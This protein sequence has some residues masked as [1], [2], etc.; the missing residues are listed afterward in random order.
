M[1]KLSENEGE[2]GEGSNTNPRYHLQMAGPKLHRNKPFFHNKKLNIPEDYGEYGLGYE[3]VYEGGKAKEEEDNVALEEKEE[4]K[5]EDE[6]KAYSDDK[7][8]AKEDDGMNGNGKIGDKEEEE[9]GDDDYDNDNAALE[10]EEY[11]YEEGQGDLHAK[12]NGKNNAAIEK[13]Q[14]YEEEGADTKKDEDLDNVAV[15]EVDDAG[16][17]H[18]D[19]GGPVFEDVG[20][21]AIKQSDGRSGGKKSQGKTKRVDGVK[22]D[23]EAKRDKAVEKEGG[24]LKE[25]VKALETGIDKME[26]VEGLDVLLSEKGKDTKAI[27]EGDFLKKKS[28]KFNLEPGEEEQRGIKVNIGGAEAAR[29]LNQMKDVEAGKEGQQGYQMGRKADKISIAGNVNPDV[30]RNAK[31]SEIGKLNPEVMGMSGKLEKLSG[32]VAAGV[33]DM[34]AMKRV[35]ATRKSRVQEVCGKYGLGPHAAPGVKPTF[36]YPPTPTYETFYIDKWVGLFFG[37]L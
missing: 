5:Y 8:D 33:D 11:K 3:E 37:L 17:R 10:E 12:T 2:V 35:M 30:V 26:E 13:G 18:K 20:G 9:E 32:G 21:V 16:G 7:K 1:K 4:Y 24:N 19:E 34:E 36:K 29:K 27:K 14:N 31:R 22:D 23:A 15:E 28:L 25:G 6:G